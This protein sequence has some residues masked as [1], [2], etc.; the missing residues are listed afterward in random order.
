MSSSASWV[1]SSARSPR[2]YLHGA[3]RGHQG[4]RPKRIRNRNQISTGVPGARGLGADKRSEPEN[5]QL[6]II[7]PVFRCPDAQDVQMRR[8]AGMRARRPWK[9]GSGS[10]S[11]FVLLRVLRGDTKNKKPRGAQRDGASEPEVQS[12]QSFFHGNVVAIVKM[13][14]PSLLKTSSVTSKSESVSTYLSARLKLPSVRPTPS[15]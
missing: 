8:I 11:D 12:D 13:T 10:D 2:N 4:K 6:T 14:R 5:F 15:E 1:R 7:S 3:H 9:F